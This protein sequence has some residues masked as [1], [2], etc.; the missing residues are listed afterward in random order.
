M[1]N[2]TAPN[3]FEIQIMKENGIDHSNVGIMYRSA[4]CIRALN[5]L[6]R[7]VIVIWKGDRKW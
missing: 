7:D 1:A 6:T 4:D 2:T 3:E 5:Y